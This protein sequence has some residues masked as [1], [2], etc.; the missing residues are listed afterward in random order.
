MNA[1]TKILIVDDREE[2]LVA[3]E[4]LLQDFDVDLIRA[5]SGNEALQQM[6]EH[7]FA[8]V[9][10]DVQMPEMDGFETVQIMRDNRELEH[11]PVIFISAIYKEEAY[12]IKGIESG[13]VD[14]IIKPIIPVVLL[15]KVN[16]FIHLYEDRKR[17]KDLNVTIKKN[18]RKLQESKSEL[19][20]AQQIA[21]IGSFSLNVP[22]GEIN[23]SD[24]LY[25]ICELSS[26][27]Q[28]T[29]DSYVKLIHPDDRPLFDKAMNNVM[30]KGETVFIDYRIICPNGKTKWIRGQS[31]TIADD[32]GNKAKIIG[33]IQDITLQKESEEKLQQAEK[34]Q[35]I[36]QL[37]GGIAHD[38]N[39]QLATIMGN[40]D[41]ALCEDKDKNYINKCLKNIITVSKRAADLTGQLLAFARKGNY[42][43]EDIN[44]NRVVREVISMLE[45]TINKKI[46]VKSHLEAD[47]YKISGDPTQIYSAIMN[48]GINARD[49]LDEEGSIYFST[50]VINISDFSEYKNAEDAEPGSY[51]E[52][53]I[54]DSGTG[55]KQD[56]IDKI[57]EPFFTTKEQGK[58][59]GMGL[60]AVLGIVKM[61]RGLIN[62]STSI[63][64][65]TTFKLLFPSI[66]D[67]IEEKQSG[68]HAISINKY[69]GTVLLADDEE[70]IC[71][72]GKA[73]LENEGF[74]VLTA[75][76]GEEAFNIYKERG[77]DIKFVILDVL[78]PVMDGK[79][80]L[81]KILEINPEAKVLITTGYMEDGPSRKLKEQGAFDI[82]KKPFTIQALSEKV[83]ELI[84]S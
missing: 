14:F 77:H 17:L 52:L 64:N 58:G 67:V 65:G 73:M 54:T 50:K 84:I 16:I 66:S 60:S 48:I 7:E 13:A 41:L 9:L 81:N 82:L 69:E 12:T 45:R 23:W 33:T 53:E 74:D 47:E 26:S 37:A 8:L 2:N 31:E 49:A 38:F 51:I 55:I 29:G 30:A 75:C 80:A 46:T 32:Q 20:K 43:K 78:M 24:E 62:V 72:V 28:I 34:M 79:E 11:T 39:N 61:H 68:S 3:L 25:R 42:L 10:M 35:V 83:S 70:M 44:I 1:K 36:G 21:K 40:A 4:K 57:F 6:I 22:T 19:I 5:F 76:N 18:E 71:A 15:G 56:V 59:T 27:T 63:E